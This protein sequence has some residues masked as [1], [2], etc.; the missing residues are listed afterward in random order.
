MSFNTDFPLDWLLQN[1]K[2]N[3]F[4]VYS[5]SI[6]YL[7]KKNISRILQELTVWA[8]PNKVGQMKDSIICSVQDNSER[9]SIDVSCWGVRPEVKLDNKQFNFE[10]IILHR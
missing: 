5:C 4:D 3:I 6:V 9:F 7:K 8:Y 10:K 2:K 1:V